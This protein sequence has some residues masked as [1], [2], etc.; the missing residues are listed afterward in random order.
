MQNNRQHSKNEI[1]DIRNKLDSTIANYY[2]LVQDFQREKAIYKDS[3]FRE[4]LNITSKLSSEEMREIVYTDTF[5]EAMGLDRPAGS[6][7]GEL[8]PLQGKEDK[9]KS[10][11]E[12]QKK[13]HRYSKLT[14]KLLLAF[15]TYTAFR[16]IN[17]YMKGKHPVAATLT[18]ALAAAQVYLGVKHEMGVVSAKDDRVQKLTDFANYAVTLIGSVQTIKLGQ[19][20]LKNVGKTTGNAAANADFKDA[21]G[22]VEKLKT[23]WSNVQSLKGNTWQSINNELPES[24]RANSPETIGKIVGGTIVTAGIVLAIYGAYGLLVKG[25]ELYDEYSEDISKLDSKLNLAGAE[26]EVVVAAKLRYLSYDIVKL[27]ELYRSKIKEFNQF[28]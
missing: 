7:T 18:M 22:F 20:I 9:N 17:M 24:I 11:E 4:S 16:S 26:A 10:D 14:G 25:E 27:K 1:Q 3:S 12:T 21:N 15:G 28:D 8:D 23:A 19:S 2:Q 13:D 6:E 5:D